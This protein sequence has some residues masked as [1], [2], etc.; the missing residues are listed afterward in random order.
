[1]RAYERFLDY[2]RI[3]TASSDKTGAH[4]STPGQFGLA[5][6]LEKQMKELGLANVRVDGH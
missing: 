6:L 1:M 2:V 4:P 3:N 5:R